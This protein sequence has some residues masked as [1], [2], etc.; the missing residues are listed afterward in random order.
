MAPTLILIRHAQALHNVDRDYSL[1]DPPL[2][3]LGHEQ[4]QR[5][6]EHLRTHQPLA[7]QIEY[8]VASP[9]RR[10]LQTMQ[11]SLEWLMQKGIK[12]ETDARWQENS[13]KPCDTGSSVSTMKQEFAELASSGSLDTIDP[14]YPSKDGQ[15]A[16]TQP[17]VIGRGMS[18]LAD[19]RKRPEKVIA[20]VSHS[21]FL[22]TAIG[23]A[24][25]NNADYR[26]YEFTGSNEYGL[27]L[28]E[29]KETEEKGGGLSI[30]E[31][32]KAPIVKGD[33]PEE[34]VEK[35][36]E[37]LGEQAQGETTKELPN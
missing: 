19:L 8:I 3:K 13:D 24:Q 6:Q 7:A 29:W 33:F 17:A 27:V 15:Y 36:R 10:T 35:V 25:W 20:V 12:A 22:R 2:S 28:K 11:E 30:S 21:G 18:A 23:Q 14:D 37:S 26:V 1:H 32:G 31:K 34:R 5:L 16:F 9:M 4:C